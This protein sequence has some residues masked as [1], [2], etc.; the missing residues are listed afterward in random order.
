MIRT[1]RAMQQRD[2]QGLSGIAI[3]YYQ[4]YYIYNYLY[5][6]ITKSYKFDKKIWKDLFEPGS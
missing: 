3:R 1:Q 6:I 4:G 2:D 5:R